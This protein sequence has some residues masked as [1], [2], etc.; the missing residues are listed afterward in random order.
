MEKKNRRKKFLSTLSLRRATSES[1]ALQTV[2]DNFYPRSPCGERQLGD[3]ASAVGEVFLSTLSL[4]RA[5]KFCG[6]RSRRHEDFYPRSPCGERHA[7]KKISN[8]FRIISIH[9]LL[10]ESDAFK[11]PLI[12]SENISIHALL[13]E[14]DH[15]R[16]DSLPNA[17]PFL[18][19]LSLRRATKDCQMRGCC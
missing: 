19:T 16:T 2:I 10:A 5:T 15:E 1:E 11:G 13:A 6:T 14:S 18:S 8:R 17:P 3:V 4:R 9:A 12:L 7:F